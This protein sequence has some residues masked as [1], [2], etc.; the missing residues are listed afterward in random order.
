VFGVAEDRDLIQRY[1]DEGAARLVFN[2]L[3]AASADEVLPLL[4]PCASLIG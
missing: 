3:P 2:L 4:D 1:R